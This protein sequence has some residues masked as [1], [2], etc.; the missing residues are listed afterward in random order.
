MNRQTT[1][2]EASAST[3]ELAAQVTTPSLCAWT[4]ARTPTNPL[5]G[6][7]WPR[8]RPAVPLQQASG[9]LTEV[10][11]PNHVVP[12]AIVGAGAACVYVYLRRLW[13]P[14]TS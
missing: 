8:K 11:A 5:D 9:A 10:P 1:I 13:R 12:L 3:N 14:R 6:W 2:S 7:T 4:P